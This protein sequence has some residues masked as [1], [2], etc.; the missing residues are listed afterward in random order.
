MKE[1]Q[2][3]CL[4]KQKISPV[5]HNVFLVAHNFKKWLGYACLEK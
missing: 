5:A 1:T 4:Y 2:P 3:V